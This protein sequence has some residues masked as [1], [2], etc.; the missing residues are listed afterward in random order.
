MQLTKNFHISEFMCHDGTPVP[1]DLVPNVQLLAKNLQVLR[2][3]LGIPIFVVSGYRTPSH[4]AKVKGAKNSQH[5][6]AKAGDLRVKGK[7]P[8]QV[9][10]AIEKLIAEKKM[11]QGGIGI[12]PT[13]THYDVRGV[14][15]R[16]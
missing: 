16:W 1:S 9:A 12:Y 5:L 6:K 4:N 7:T 13:F 11:M 2:D 3:T 8:K 14:K 15:A 10:D